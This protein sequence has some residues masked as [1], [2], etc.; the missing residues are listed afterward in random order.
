MIDS[1]P[2]IVADESQMIQVMQNLISNAIKFSGPQ[3][4]MIWISATIGIEGMDIL[5]Q[6]QRDRA[7]HGV[8]QKDYF[9]CS[10]AF[11]PKTCTRALAWGWRLT[12]KIIEWHDG[13][14]WV[15]SEEGKGATLLFTI[16]TRHR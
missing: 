16:P 11:I 13:K 3:K 8:L 14:I 9:Q 7:G 1:L 4:P 10:S 15:E 12:K 5:R 6:E 2:A